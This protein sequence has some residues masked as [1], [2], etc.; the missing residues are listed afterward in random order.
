MEAIHGSTNEIYE[1][2]I[3]RDF[4]ILKKEIKELQDILK[5]ISISIEDDI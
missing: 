5:D 3:D 2:L 4:V 1:A